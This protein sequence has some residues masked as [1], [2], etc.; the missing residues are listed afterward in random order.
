MPSDLRRS[1]S[2]PQADDAIRERYPLY[3]LLPRGVNR[4]HSGHENAPEVLITLPGL[5]SGRN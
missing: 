2:E 5:V 4:P 3:D 1:A